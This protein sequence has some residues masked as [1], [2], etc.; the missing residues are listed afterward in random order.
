MTI[1][2]SSG[3]TRIQM[4]CLAPRLK[5]EMLMLL[6]DSRLEF[7]A[8]VVL[9]RWWRFEDLCVVGGVRVAWGQS[10]IC[11]DAVDVFQQ[12]GPRSARDAP[13]ERS[14]LIL[15]G[16]LWY[17]LSLLIFVGLHFWRCLRE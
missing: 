11:G 17:Y 13:H 7:Q 2:L 8:L 16:T 6:N 12:K 15:S 5:S 9:G 10:P 1:G 14:E 4:R 3:L